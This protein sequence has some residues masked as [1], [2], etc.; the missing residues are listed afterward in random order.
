MNR[1][2][3]KAFLALPPLVLMLVSLASAQVLP[4]PEGKVEFIGLHHWTPEQVRDTLAALDVPLTSG[5]CAAVLELEVGFPQ[6]AVN[7]YSYTDSSSLNHSVI[8]LV[9]PEESDR[10]RYLPPPADSLGPRERWSEAY[11]FLE[12]SRGWAWNVGVQYRDRPPPPDLWDRLEGVDTMDFHAVRDFLQRH[13]T[14]DDLQLALETL[15]HDRNGLSRI[16]AV[17]ILGG[18][19]QR[20]E[21]LHAVVRAARGF[22]QRDWGRAKAAGMLRELS[23][24]PT[25]AID[26]YPVAEDLSA[27]MSGTNL[28]AFMPIL[29]LLARTGL[30]PELTKQLLAGGSPLVID[31]LAAESPHPR[32]AARLFL[33]R[34][35]GESYGDDVDAWK[36]WIASL[37]V[38][39]ASG[40]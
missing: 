11:D 4:T 16:I 25:E 13:T 2:L 8:T 20:Q 24:N 22:G 18:F 15:D 40:R 10:V 27:L 17:G 34:V 32:Q 38:S 30:P 29:E 36:A 26:W 12:G 6:A 7:R 35:S 19:P 14:E 5:A 9:E 21:S 23:A 28:F 3:W 31:H 1:S 37:E 39:E 33:E